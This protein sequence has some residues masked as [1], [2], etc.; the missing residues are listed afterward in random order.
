MEHQ[1]WLI[2]DIS[3]PINYNIRLRAIFFSS[4]FVAGNFISTI[5]PRS[6]RSKTRPNQYN[7]VGNLFFRLCGVHICTQNQ[8]KTHV[9]ITFYLSIFNLWLAAKWL[10]MIHMRA[11]QSFIQSMGSQQ[12]VC[13]TS[14]L[15]ICAPP[16]VRSNMENAPN[17]VC[18]H[19]FQFQWKICCKQTTEICMCLVK[20]QYFLPNAFI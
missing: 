2:P 4:L 15:R 7:L 11:W 10:K 16:S 14:L 12:N 19:V 20:P 8:S 6:K 17:V 5:S 9:L 13:R 3:S 18:A 1:I